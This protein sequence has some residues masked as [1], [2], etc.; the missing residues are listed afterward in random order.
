MEEKLTFKKLLE[1][2]KPSSMSNKEEGRLS[3][4][5]IWNM[6]ANK[7]SFETMGFSSEDELSAWIAD[8][9]YSSIL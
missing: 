3:T 6:I 7:E 9:P 2:L 4:K 1:S 5:E 8:N